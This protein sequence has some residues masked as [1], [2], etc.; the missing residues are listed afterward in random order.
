MCASFTTELTVA[1]FLPETILCRQKLRESMHAA[2]MV[3]TWLQIGSVGGF[4][5]KTALVHL[6][7]Y[8]F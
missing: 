5:L 1:F 7:L 8:I 4:C 6:H 2:G 3:T